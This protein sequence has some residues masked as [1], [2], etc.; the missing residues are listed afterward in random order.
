MPILNQTHDSTLAG[1]APPSWY[2]TLSGLLV[3]R[4]LE[5]ARPLVT[6][7]SEFSAVLSSMFLW[8]VSSELWAVI[9]EL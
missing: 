2:R 9:H 1:L 3:R 6:R 8:I 4:P 5:L 7:D